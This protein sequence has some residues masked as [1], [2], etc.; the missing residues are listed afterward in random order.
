MNFGLLLP[1]RVVQVVDAVTYVVSLPGQIEITVFLQGCKPT[2]VT[3]AE[4][5]ADIE[6]RLKASKVVCWLP[7]PL[8]DRGWFMGLR[9]GCSFAGELI[10]TNY[11]LSEQL[12]L[13]S[14]V[15]RL[16][17]NQEWEGDKWVR[18]WQI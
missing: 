18:T 7:A 9:P 1:C 16:T 8:H 15:V 13:E 6:A 5:V 11:T 4:T 3:P 17:G 2:G 14:I 10:L 12:A